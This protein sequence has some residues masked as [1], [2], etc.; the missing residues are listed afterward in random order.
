[1]WLRIQMP[2]RDL[3][4]AEPVRVKERSVTVLSVQED[5]GIGP[6]GTKT[7]IDKNAG[8]QKR[9]QPKTLKDKIIELI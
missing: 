8:G 5:Q 2:Q 3:P 6:I 9:P 1:M 7:P 4:G